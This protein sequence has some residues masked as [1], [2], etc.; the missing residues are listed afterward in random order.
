MGKITVIIPDDLENRVRKMLATKYS[1][2]VHGKL[3]ELVIAALEEYLKGKVV[4]K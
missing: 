3:T 1:G 2:K 4:D